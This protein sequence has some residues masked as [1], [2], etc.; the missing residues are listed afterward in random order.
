MDD[1]YND[2]KELEALRAGDPEA[3]RRLIE[4]EAPRVYRCI[5]RI[6]RN[7]DEARNLTQETFAV[8][9]E[10]IKDFR[11]DAKLSTWLCAIGINLARSAL[12]KALR[13]ES[14]DEETINQLQPRFIQGRYAEP[15]TAWS[16]EKALENKELGALIEKALERLPAPY[17]TVIVLRDMEGLSTEEVAQ[18]L[19]I[20]E[21]AVRVRLHRARQAL[22]KI[23]DEYFREDSA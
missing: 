12:R 20:S 7:E 4:R 9:Y 14:L 10:R 6:I 13:H 11:G 22:R 19:G 23:L 2:T 8:A 18:I 1:A 16:P 21:G 3:F 5:Y 17:R 15:V